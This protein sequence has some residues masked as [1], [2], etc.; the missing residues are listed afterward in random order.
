M[1]TFTLKTFNTKPWRLTLSVTLLALAAGF[2]HVALAAPFGGPGAHGEHGAFGEHGGHGMGGAPRFMHRM[3]DEVKA[4]P[5]QR[6]QIKQITDAAHTDLQALRDAGRKLREQNRALFLQPTVDRRAAEVLRQQS[7][8]H[9]DQVSKRMLQMKLEISRVLTPEQRAQMGER[10]KR[11]ED[12]M[13]RHRL[14][15][16]GLEKPRT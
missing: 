8:A 7:Q 14:E 10:M 15:R 12:M 6:L 16:D 1:N 5:E 13:Q 3:L 11:R 2:S 4:T 9:H